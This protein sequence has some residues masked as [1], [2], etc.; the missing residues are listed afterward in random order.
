MSKKPFKISGT[1]SVESFGI[2][3]YVN[4][5]DKDLQNIFK[6]IQLTPRF[7][8]Q[9]TEPSVLSNDFAFWKDTSVSK[10]YIVV[11]FNGTQKKVELT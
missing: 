1:A 4:D 7:Y 2:K 11:N 5:I 10:Y 6:Y 3:Q 9:A 8:T